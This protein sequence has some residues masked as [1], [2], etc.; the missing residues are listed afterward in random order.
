ME[1]TAD[2]D[3]GCIGIKIGL[4]GLTLTIIKR[5]THGN[6][7]DIGRVEIARIENKKRK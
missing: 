3:N 7:A 6:I 5:C 2:I 4:I 1:H